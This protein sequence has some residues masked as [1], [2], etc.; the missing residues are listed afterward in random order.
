MNRI[1]RI[2]ATE[3]IVP[4]KPGSINSPLLDRPLHKLESGGQKA[5]TKQ[6]D[7]FPKLILQL[8]LENGVIGLGECYRD[9]D[10]RI[11]ENIIQTLLGQPI[12]ALK[13]QALPIAI[14][15]EYDGFECAIW[16]AFARTH[17]LPLVDLLGGAL[18]HEILVSA[19][20]GHRTVDEMGDIAR[21]F[22][23]EGYMCW[24]LKCDLEDDV[25]S[26][27]S[28]IARAAPNLKV[29]LDPNERWERPDEA[30]RRLRELEKIGNVLCLEDPIPHWLMDEYSDLRRFS[31]IPI[32]RHVSL[33][34]MAHGQR[35]H[36]AIVAIQKRAVD[37]FNFNGGLAKFHQ[38]AQIAAGAELPFWHGSEVDL[39]ILEAMYIHQCAAAE[40]C[41]LPSDIFGR[42]VRS[43]DLLQTPLTFHPP[44]VT[45]PDGIGLG[46][47]LD[48]AAVAAYQTQKREFIL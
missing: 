10:W 48:P 36:D 16:D 22:A 26:W 1:V 35:V 28:E 27:C 12:S 3:V 5:W 45:L 44:Y 19:W 30:K 34:Y 21:R 9:H 46:I 41:T 17:Q 29:I 37:G 20:T 47:E 23:A 14:C 39:G 13:R 33:P 24:K 40:S 11:V 4:A 8:E 32:V 43:H 6:F 38:L 31:S 7:E 2:I 18:R 25:I 42:M 15:R